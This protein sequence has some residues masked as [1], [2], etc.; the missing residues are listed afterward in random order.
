MKESKWLKFQ[1]HMMTGISYMIPVVMIAGVLMG[2]TSLIGN[3]MGFNPGDAELLKHPDGLVSLIAWINQVAGKGLM[4]LMY[5]IL[6]AY[7][8]FGIADRPGLAPGL[9]GGML[10]LSSNAGFIGA[11]ITG[12]LAGYSVLGLN[13]W[14]QVPRRYIGIKSMFLLPIVGSLIV[15]FGVKL[16]V[17]PIGIG[18]TN[19]STWFVKTIGE[20][21]GAMLSAAFAAARASDFG[22]PINKAAGT[23]GKQLYFDSGYPYIGLMI[24][25]VIPSIGIGLST[26]LDKYI[27][28]EKVYTPQLQQSGIPCLT[29]GFLGIAEGAIP[30]AIADPMTIPIAMVGSAVGGAIGFVMGCDIF[31]GSSYGFFVWPL[32]KN[33]AGFMLALIVGVLIVMFLMIWRNKHLKTIREK[34]ESINGHV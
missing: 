3:S 7:I 13:K 6:S 28:R 1:Q 18:L 2:V 22:G 20:Q 23:I 14:I 15:L 26:I 33:F 25:C 29:L 17:A 27:V 16:I 19:I 4:R 32:I 30:F 31:P 9:M 34:K 5:P 12:F 21:G 8:A 10:A 11:L 24:G